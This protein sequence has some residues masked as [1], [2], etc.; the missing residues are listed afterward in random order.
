[1]PLHTGHMYLLETAQSQCEK[2]T[3]LL[4][5]QP[6]DPIG[7]DVRLEWLKKKFP[8]ANVVHHPDPL[9]R[10]QSDPHFWDLWRNSIRKYCPEKFDVVF[11]SESYGP[12]LAQELG[13]I[14]V[15]VDPSR[16]KFPVSGTDIRS[17]PIKFWEFIPDIVRP[18]F[19]NLQN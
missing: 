5:S 13:S 15:A 17:N 11:S 8:Q 9:P 19:E 12:R 1:M 10:D 14:H 3:I 18:Y 7:G 6:D 4:C 16:E 2:L